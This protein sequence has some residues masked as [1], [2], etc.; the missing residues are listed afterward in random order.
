[1][2]DWSPPSLPQGWLAIGVSAYL[3][4]LAY[5]LLIARQVL[6]GVLIGLFLALFYFL[7]R[8]LAALEAIA[9]AQQRLAG[10]HREDGPDEGGHD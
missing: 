1:M 9:D 5:A 4:V 8:F 6:L 2:S 10:D 3:L 7:W